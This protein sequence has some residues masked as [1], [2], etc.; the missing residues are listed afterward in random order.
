[1]TGQARPDEMGWRGI[2]ASHRATIC[3]VPNASTTA[4][5]RQATDGNVRWWY[6]LLVPEVTAIFMS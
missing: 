2:G 5:E 3:A 6:G 4:I 1:M